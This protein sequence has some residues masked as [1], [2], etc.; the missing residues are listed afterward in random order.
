MNAQSPSRDQSQRAIRPLALIQSS[1]AK[2]IP[3][4]LLLY[5]ISLLTS[6][7]G[8]EI[9]GWSTCL[10]TLLFILTGVMTSGSRN[11]FTLGCEIP[12]LA[13][14]II[15]YIGLQV[16]APDADHLTAMGKLRWVIML[17]LLTYSLN[18][19]SG[20]NRIIS[21]LI[22]V[23]TIVGCYAIF[24]HFTGI[25]LVRGDHRAVTI[26][27]FEGATVFQNTGFLSHHLTYGYS[28]AMLFCFPFA[29][30]L[31][32]R[33]KPLMFK[34]GLGFSVLV[35]GLSLLWTYGRGVWIASVVAIFIIAAYVSKKHFAA[36]LVILGIIGGVLYTGNQGF[37]ERFESIWADNYTSNTDR[38]DLWRANF[39]MFQDHPWI[40]VGYGQ[41]EEI[42]GQYYKNLDIKN[43]FG[44]HAHNNYLQVL[45]TTGLLGFLCY[46]FFILSFLLMTHRLWT[47]VPKTHYWH[48]VFILG[49]LGAQISLHAGGVTQWNFGDAEVNHLF[50]FILAMIAYMSERYSRGIV[51]D[52]Y[53][54]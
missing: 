37:Q 45:S 36:L 39:A 7:S 10:L 47:E 4:F 19:Y 34:I 42:L 9:F 25:D 50:I 11:V 15:A 40:G 46:M 1:I 18:I 35:I 8:M 43:D 23:G 52:D 12:L 48:R 6:M 22:W 49:S 31:L 24:Q 3:L 27:P 26:A 14:I 5:T 51:P 13:F 32:G 54:L 33:R 29:A 17:Y 16:N 21:I 38:K 2:L 53:S 30:L 41:N 20:L 44:G 28:F